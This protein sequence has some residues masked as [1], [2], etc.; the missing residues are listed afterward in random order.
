MS[1]REER[2]EDD[3]AVE[4]DAVVIREALGEGWTVYANWSRGE[5]SIEVGDATL[6]YGHDGYRAMMHL[7][8]E[9]IELRWA[10]KEKRDDERA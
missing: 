10:A 1:E 9:V 6:V 2:H 3:L 8:H 5:R 7:C 4:R